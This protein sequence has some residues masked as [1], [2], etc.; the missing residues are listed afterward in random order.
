[1]YLPTLQKTIYEKSKTQCG[2]NDSHKKERISGFQMTLVRKHLV[3]NEIIRVELTY[4]DPTL[5]AGN[6]IVL[7][8]MLTYIIG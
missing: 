1:M 4:T 2:I 7:S 3:V 8:T 6:G 5:Q